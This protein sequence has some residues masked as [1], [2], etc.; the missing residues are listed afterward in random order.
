MKMRVKKVIG[1]YNYNLGGV[2]GHI[3]GRKADPIPVGA[4]VEAEMERLP[5]GMTITRVEWLPSGCDSY[6]NT[7]INADLGVAGD[8]YLQAV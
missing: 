6:G 2:P 1:E 3:S 7:I 4:I 5:N 8:D